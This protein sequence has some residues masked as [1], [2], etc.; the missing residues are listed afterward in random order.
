M[1]HVR[2][3][4]TTLRDGEQAAGGALTID[5]KLEIGR[6]LARLQVDVIE[7]GF[8]F[9]SP[10]DFKAVELLSRELKDVEVAALSG[11][12]R[13]QIDATWEALKGAERPLLHIVI[14]TSDIHLEH[15]LR[16]R[17]ESVI[18]MT[19]EA[20]TYVRG[21]TDHIEFS[22]MDATRS[23]IGFVADVFL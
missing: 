19:R 12:K 17:R 14:S 11:F 9:T 4:D 18:D 16:E 1:R 5:E 7:A 2:I 22:A 21:K 13:E 15:Q 8:P 20:V 23:D 6:Q 10:G 3:F